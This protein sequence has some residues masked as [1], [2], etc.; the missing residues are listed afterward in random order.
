VPNNKDFLPNPLLCHDP[1]PNQN[2]PHG[3]MGRKLLQAPASTCAPVS[4]HDNTRIL[5]DEGLGLLQAFE[6]GSNSKSR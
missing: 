4:F 3:I 2:W 6:T 5:Q 1:P